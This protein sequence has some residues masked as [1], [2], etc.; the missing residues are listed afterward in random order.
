MRQQQWERIPEMRTPPWQAA[1]ISIGDHANGQPLFT[2]DR[3]SAQVAAP[4]PIL[5][6]HWFRDDEI[7]RA[8]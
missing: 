8:A 6:E 3:T 2:A 4:G 5:T 1:L 7:R